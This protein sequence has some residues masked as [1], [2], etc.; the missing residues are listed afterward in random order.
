[1]VIALISYRFA[2][3]IV[4]ATEITAVAQ[5]FHFE[6][7]EDYLRSVGYPNQ[8]LHWQF[9]QDTSPSVWVG[10]FLLVI[11]LINLLPVRIYGE[12]EYILGCFKIAVICGMVLFNFIVNIRNTNNGT[13]QSRFEY[14]KSPYGFFSSNTT[15]GSNTE[16]Y[17]YS[18]S[19]GKLIGM[20][21]A[22]NT[23]FFS[24]QGFFTVAITAAENKDLERDESIKLATRKIS[25][26]V[27]LLYTLFVFTAGLNIPYNDQNL[28]DY[29]I[30][31]IRRG[32][33]SSIMI[34]CVRSHITGWPHFLNAFFIFSAFST[35][36]NS[37]Y[38]SSRLLH[39]LANIQ[40]VWPRIKWVNSIRTRLERTTS[41][42]VPATA[43]FVSW[44]FGLLGFLAS[45]PF[46]AKV[47]PV[48]F[49]FP[50][51]LGRL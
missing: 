4:V 19:T 10:I 40:N 20:W 47:R 13:I 18:G 1:M 31:S 39:A 23:I 16:T 8:T 29:S 43:I 3:V 26:R 34:G 14:Y 6:F 38:I 28:R 2:Y 21:T 17:V 41:K 35:G 49:C 15:T 50:W 30:N 25:L 12:V 11:L 24:L 48:A 46:P 27:I 5:L 33:Y 37:L 7:T 22:M 51:I 44:L 42:G 32:Q 9:G 45:K 36:I